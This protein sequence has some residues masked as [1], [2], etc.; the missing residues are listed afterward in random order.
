[1][2]SE[3]VIDGVL[4]FSFTEGMFI[5]YSDIQLTAMLLDSRMHELRHE[6]PLVVSYPQI[7][8]SVYP[9]PIDPYSDPT[10][11][12]PMMNCDEG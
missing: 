7:S 11:P 4:N 10:L 8:E 12:I 1:M 2:I 3:K 5:P 9:Q 6:S